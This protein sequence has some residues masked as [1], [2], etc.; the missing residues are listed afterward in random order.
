MTLSGKN[1]FGCTNIST[2]YNKQYANAHTNFFRAPYA[3]VDFMS[4]QNLGGKTLLY[5]MDALYASKEVNDNDRYSDGSYHGVDDKWP[6][7]GNTWPG[8]VMASQDGVAL[9]SVSTDFYQ[10]NFPDV[11]AI[12]KG[13]DKYLHDAAVPTNSTYVGVNGTG[14]LTTSLGVHEHWNNAT[15]RQYSGNL[16]GTGI[17]LAYAPLTVTT[18]L[19]DVNGDNAL[20]IVDALLIAQYV[21]G[22]NPL[23]FDATVADVNCSTKI[24]IVD[25]LLLA[26]YCAGLITTLPCK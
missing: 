1:F 22:L 15:D 21:G 8:M 2:N 7:F 3:F 4:C 11:N 23:K 24:D 9:D 25:A 18:L 19:G 26:Q 6:M 16:G 14:R 13:W 20:T 17:E 10:A 12:G 5:M